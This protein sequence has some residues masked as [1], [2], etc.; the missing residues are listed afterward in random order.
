MHPGQQYGQCAEARELHKFLLRALREYYFRDP[1][2]LLGCTCED[3]SLCV[4]MRTTQSERENASG[5]ID[6]DF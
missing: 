1:Y 5:V 6:S 2:E 3:Y 4:S